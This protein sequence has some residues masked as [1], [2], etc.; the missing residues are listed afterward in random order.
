VRPIAYINIF[1]I[2]IQLIS[3]QF[4]SVKK[5]RKREETSKTNVKKQD[6]QSGQHMSCG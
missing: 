4:R 5:E 1:A 6:I 2:I 3:V